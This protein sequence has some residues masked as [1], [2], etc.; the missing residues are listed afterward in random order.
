MATVVDPQPSE[1]Q[2]YQRLKHRA[3]FI[4]LALNF[5]GLI[6]AVL[7][8]GPRLDAA[9][10]PV[11]GDS[12]WLRLGILGLVYGFGLEL[13]TLPVDFWSGYLLEHRF[14]LS[15]QSFGAWA[16]KKVKGWLLLAPFGLAMLFGLYALLI[17]AGPWWW[18]WATAAWLLVVVVLGQLVPVLILPLFYHVERLEDASL[19]ERLRRLASGTGLAVEGVYEFRLSDETSKGNAALAG[20]GRTRRVLLGDTLLNQFTP[21]EI[22]IVFAHELGHHVHRHLPKMIAVEVVLSAVGLWLVDRML[23]TLASAFGYPVWT[24]PA[25]LPLLLLVL[26]TFGLVLSPL[27]NA[28]SRRFERQCDRYALDRTQDRDAYRSAFTKLGKLNKADADPHPIVVWLFH[29]HPTI[30]ERIAM[31]E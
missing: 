4:N 16:W 12:P 10:R 3:L 21:E 14:G 13:L 11:V 29:D 20:L 31:V 30:R 24:D 9:L 5:A 18:V 1:S 27:T 17:W 7:L 19:L 25:A 22:D 15:R 26:T 2:H 28:L 6:I 8:I 23:P